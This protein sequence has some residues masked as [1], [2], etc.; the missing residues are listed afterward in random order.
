M[1]DLQTTKLNT[2]T[3]SFITGS[4]TLEPVIRWGQSNDVVLMTFKL[5]HRWDTPT[6]NQP[7]EEQY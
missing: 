5:S 1:L 4:S 6:C 3:K 2:L 7:L